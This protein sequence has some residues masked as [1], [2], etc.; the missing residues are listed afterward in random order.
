M[1]SNKMK[2]V[3]CKCFCRVPSDRGQN[4]PR[5]SRGT[6]VSGADISHTSPV[7]ANQAR[8]VVSLSGTDS[9]A[10]DLN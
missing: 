8:R 2:E 7:S 4:N 6:A 10:L 9:A 3:P 5:L 1:M